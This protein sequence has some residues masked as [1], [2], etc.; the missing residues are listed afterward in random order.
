[1]SDTV[2]TPYVPDFGAEAERLKPV[3]IPHTRAGYGSC[4][5][6]HPDGRRPGDRD[7]PQELA[8]AMTFGLACCAIEMIGTFMSNHDLDRF[9]IV[10]GRA[11]ARAT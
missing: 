6:A 5:P 11:R 4:C 10:R 2:I 9:G 3:E 7:E 1:M 8:L